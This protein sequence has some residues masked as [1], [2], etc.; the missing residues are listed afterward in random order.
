MKG[1]IA[2]VLAIVTGAVALLGCDS[3]VI[4]YREFMG[5][6]GG[7]LEGPDGTSITVPESALSG[8]TEVYILKNPKGSDLP[9]GTVRV[10]EIGPVGTQLK[11]PAVFSVPSGLCRPAK[12]SLHGN[13]PWLNLPRDTKSCASGFTCADVTVMGNIA[14]IKEAE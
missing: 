13:G 11:I 8:Q 12:W 10:Y 5:S 14:C 6:W 4:P 1:Y 9:S 2:A 7:T 3:T